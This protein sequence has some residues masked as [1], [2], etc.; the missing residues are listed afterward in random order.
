MMEND[1]R[2]YA[3]QVADWCERE[4]KSAKAAGHLETRPFVQNAQL[5]IDALREYARNLPSL[6]GKAEVS[7]GF[8]DLTKDVSRRSLEPT[9]PKAE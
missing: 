3:A 2:R 9:S 4:L 6:A 1:E 8:R 5:I 7:D